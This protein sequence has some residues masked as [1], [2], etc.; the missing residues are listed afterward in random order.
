MD[1]TPFVDVYFIDPED[2]IYDWRGIYPRQTYLA[3]LLKVIMYSVLNLKLYALFV[4]NL[5]NIGLNKD[6]ELALRESNANWKIVVGHHAIRSVS[7]HGDTP[8]LIDQLL[9]MLEVI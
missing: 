2:C 3:N 4:Y 9:P 6:L 7:H 1:T 8:E 5:A